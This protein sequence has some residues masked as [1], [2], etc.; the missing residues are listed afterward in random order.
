MIESE[1]RL[2]DAVAEAVAETP[3]TDIHTHLF[4]PEFG[5]LCLRGMDDLLSYHYLAAEA[6]RCLSMPYGEFWGLP[7]RARAD[8]V[9]RTLFLER[10]PVSEACRGVLTVLRAHGLDPGARDLEGYRAYFAGLSAQVHAGRVLEISGVERLVMTNDPFDT[11]ESGIWRAGTAVDGRFLPAL[12]LDRLLNDWP[13]ALAALGRQGYDAA[14]DPSPKTVSVIRRFLADWIARLRPVYLAASLPPDF[15]W[16]GDSPRSRLL[17][18]AVLPAA[19]EH[20]LPLAM[21]LGVRRGVNPELGQ[22]GDG[23]G[24]AS[25]VP[26]ENLCAAFPE[27]RF[28][29]TALARENQH[30]ACVLGRKFRNLMP[31]G[32]WWFMNNPVLAQETTAMRLEMLGLSFIPQHSDARVLDQLLYKWAHFR[33]ILAGT[34][35][36]RYADLMRTGWRVSREEIRRDVAGLL[37]E[38]FWGFLGA[39]LI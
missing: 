14:P 32:C 38:N 9:W 30:G 39:S 10:S 22:A 4:P 28:L 35:A 1:A 13:E 3:V 31:F 17:G 15:A 29:L 24:A 26:V 36:G 19:A 6:L 5:G 25:L 11:V 37:G 27:N 7:K 12:R 2:R 33:E 18:E 20:G 23:M 34:L 21:M 16:P 8:L